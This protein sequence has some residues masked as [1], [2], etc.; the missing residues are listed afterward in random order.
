MG[1][2]IT[3]ITDTITTVFGTRPNGIVVTGMATL[4]LRALDS[5]RLLL[6]RLSGR[7]PAYVRVVA[8]HQMRC[9]DADASA[10][11]LYHS[12][13]NMAWLRGGRHPVK[14]GASTREF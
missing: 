9:G 1:R 13:L 2:F 5:A 12:S 4:R 7:K 3:Q 8:R 6:A 11:R 10:G 14:R